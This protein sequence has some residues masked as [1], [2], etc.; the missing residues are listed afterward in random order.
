LLLV[1]FSQGAGKERKEL[2]N[3]VKKMFS[4]KENMEVRNDRTDDC[5][6]SHNDAAE[7]A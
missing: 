3:R 7:R 4:G 5:S 1:I 2:E 6:N